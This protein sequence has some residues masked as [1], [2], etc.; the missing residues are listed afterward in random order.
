LPSAVTRRTCAGRSG[1]PRAHDQLAAASA[2]V[3]TNLT[4][5]IGDA[6]VMF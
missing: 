1:V 2:K 5:R 6:S 4:Y 3:G